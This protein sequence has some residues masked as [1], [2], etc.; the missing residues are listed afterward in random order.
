MPNILKNNIIELI[1]DF[2][3]EHYNFSRFDWS[4]KIR[5]V[6]FKDVL[7]SSIER[8]DDVNER[9]VGKG[10]YNEFGIDSPLGFE[11]TKI[12]EWFHK[13]GVGL[14]KKDSHQYDFCKLYE[15]I[16][17]AFTTKFSKESFEICCK[18][19][20]VNGYAYELT[21]EIKLIENKFVITYHLKNTGYKNIITDEYVHNFIAF[22][23]ELISENYKLNF[24]FK[25]IPAGFIETVNPENK[26]VIESNFISFKS[27]PIQ[28][29]FFSNLSGG[30]FVNAGWELQNKTK[31]IRISETVNFETN[32]INLWGWQHVISPE[33]FFKIK[34]KPGESVEWMR[35]FEINQI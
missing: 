25:L 28:Q 15:I 4:G 3:L 20:E 9:H 24:S 32:K 6:K 11:E 8:T 16:P 22:D 5:S 12:G 21:K 10:F 19:E 1:I 14:L 29:F 35:I 18:S 13:I 31:R 33:V 27:T 2:P 30:N 34:I 26:M 23:N 17:A 7:V